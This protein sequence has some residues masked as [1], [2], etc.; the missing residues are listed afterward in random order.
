[1]DTVKIVMGLVGYG[2]IGSAVTWSFAR[3]ESLKARFSLDVLARKRPESAPEDP[4]VT[5]VQSPAEIAARSDI[6]ILAVRPE[7][8]RATVADLL[9]SWPAG[10]PDKSRLLVSLA[11]GVPLSALEEMG[12]GKMAV[13]RVMPN[14]L[15]EVNRGLFGLCAEKG[16]AEGLKEAV[17]FFFGG[18]GMVIDLEEDNQMNVFTALAGCGPGFLF[19]LMDSFSEA[20]V[21]VGLSRRA[22]LSIAIGLMG[23]CAELAA[24]TG[25]H[26]ALLR[27][28]GV[29]PAGMTIA[30]INHLDRYGVR[31]H[32]IDAV[33]T[34]CER[35]A[36]M[37]RE[38]VAG[39]KK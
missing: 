37:D 9:R 26:P 38:T 28:Q 22:S 14:T 19:Y 5:F 2:V 11:S 29:S 7:Q 24:S 10:V 15:V 30:G 1:M 3:S 21:S 18:L 13:A 25:R 17:R 33:K 36:A 4:A 39:Y 12:R 16:L 34:A 20:G 8:M 32:I 6:I 31:G 35:G 27:E 23:G